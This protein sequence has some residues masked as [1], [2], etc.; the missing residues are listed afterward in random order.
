M[1]GIDLLAFAPVILDVQ[2]YEFFAL[3]ARYLAI[4]GKLKYFEKF[5]APRPF[6][7][8]SSNEIAPDTKMPLLAK[9]CYALASAYESFSLQRK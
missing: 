8:I 7:T 6:F 2:E 5:R 4:S 1:A 9:A 3:T